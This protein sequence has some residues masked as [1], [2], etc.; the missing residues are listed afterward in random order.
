MRMT[1]LSLGMRGEVEDERGAHLE[2]RISE[3]ARLGIVFL[4]LFSLVCTLE[5]QAFVDL[6]T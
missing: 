6:V 3:E 5:A 1:G 2:V 4:C